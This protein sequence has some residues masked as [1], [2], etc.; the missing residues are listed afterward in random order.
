M[1]KKLLTFFLLALLAL[2]PGLFPQMNPS[3]SAQETDSSVP[4]L[5]AFHDII[6]PIWHTAYPQ[7]DYA[8]L[9]QFVPEVNSLAAK[10]FG[11][12]LPG[13]LRD[14]EPKW[15]EGLVQFR[16]SVEDYTAASAGND[17][18]A[19]LLAAEVLHA[20]YEILNRIISP[21]LKEM[22]E[23]HKVLY[24]VYH[25]HLPENNFAQIKIVSG[26]LKAKAEAVATATLPKRLE[27]KSEPFKS[28]AAELVQAA[29]EFDSVCGTGDDAAIDA[30]VNKLHAKYQNLEKLFS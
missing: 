4:E 26:D 11:A 28:A 30:A 6:F 25:K 2:S 8:A 5:A 9:R 14:K 27:A 19:L 17:D 13:I 3:P 12:K 7:K 1:S 29:A 21:V 15:K 20:K 22:D 10:I 24:V 18:A 23:F 16:K